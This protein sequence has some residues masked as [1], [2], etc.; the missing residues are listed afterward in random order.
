MGHL[1]KVSCYALVLLSLLVQLACR[2]AN[3]S[4]VPT[5]ATAKPSVPYPMGRFLFQPYEYYESKEPKADGTGFFVAATNGRIAAVMSANDLKFDETRLKGIRAL[6]IGDWTPIDALGQSW[7]APGSPSGDDPKADRRNDCI[8]MPVNVKLPPDR[9]LLL[10]DRPAPAVGEP[11]WLPAKLESEPRG[12]ELLDGFVQFVKPG[13]IR[14]KLKKPKTLRSHDGSPVISA[15]TGKVI[16]VLS[17]SDKVQEESILWLCP[18]SAVR[19]AILKAD[20][21][22]AL[23]DVIGGQGG[24]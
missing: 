24:Q 11:V 5:S 6:S 8:I 13:Y 7:G 18:A 21:F 1:S 2:P 23:R 16:G 22:P 3:T 4:K 20:K 10:D 12:Y 15:T 17:H 9:V 19:N 14:V